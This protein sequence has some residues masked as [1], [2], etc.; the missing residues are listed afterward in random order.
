MG[1]YEIFSHTYT[2]YCKFMLI[3]R[4]VLKLLGDNVMGFVDIYKQ[5]HSTQDDLSFMQ[6]AVKGFYYGYNN[7]HI[8]FIKT[9][10]STYAAVSGQ[11]ADLV[12]ISVDE[13]IGKSDF[14]LLCEAKELAQTF[15]DQDR[16]VEN[17]R[18]KHRFLDIN[19]YATGIG[20]YIFRKS[21]IINPATNNVLGTYCIVSKF[22]STSAINAFI[23]FQNQ[24]KKISSQDLMQYKLLT[25]RE[26]ETLF[27][28]ANGLTD[29]KLIA[30]FLSIIHKK[31]VGIE[32]T[33]KILQSLYQKL[34]CASNI[35]ALHEYAI[36]HKYYELIPEGLIG[37]ISS[38]ISIPY[39]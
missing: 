36:K 39:D 37:K 31:E 3:Y 19:H 5:Y 22:K 2:A 8:S 20:I 7:S 18:K 17:T 6:N 9:T 25:P 10:S 12:G 38:G 14:E 28:V 16:L 23:N 33:K 29:R 24:S 13:L 15:Y 21:P 32:A 27:C 1:K 35:P 26:Q 34:P 30:N 4:K 11:Y